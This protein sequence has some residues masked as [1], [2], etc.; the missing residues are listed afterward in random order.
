MDIIIL[1]YCSHSRG[2]IKMANN[3]GESGHPC[4]VPLCNSKLGD[5]SPLVMTVAIGELYSV[6]IQLI[7]VSPNPNI[8]NVANRN[9]Q[10]TLSN[11]FS[12]S[13]EAMI[14][15]ILFWVEWCTRLNSLPVLL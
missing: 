13:N 6:L 1:S 12:A 5:V 7:N 14:V 8:S 2:S 10:F 4:L 15:S 11:A 3:K 9:V